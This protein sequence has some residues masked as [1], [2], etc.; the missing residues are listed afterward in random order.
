VVEEGQQAPDFELA[1]D[2][3]VQVAGALTEAGDLPAAVRAYS[4][5]LAACP[6]ETRAVRGLLRVAERIL[7]EKG[8]P[9]SAAK[10]YRYL[11]EHCA[12]SPLVEFMR[13]GL[14]EAERALTP[15]RAARAAPGTGA[16]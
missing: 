14:E 4:T 12:S 11:L 3:G 5:V 1:S 7:H 6:G 16:G 13:C 9:D 15:P 2:T 10:V 8:R